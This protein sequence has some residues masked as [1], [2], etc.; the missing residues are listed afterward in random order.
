MTLGARDSEQ[1]S[2]EK[3]EIIKAINKLGGSVTAADVATETGLSPDKVTENLNLIASETGGSLQVSKDGN[4]AYAFQPG[5]AATYLAQGLKLFGLTV[6]N[7]ACKIGDFLLRISFGLGLLL[8]LGLI[9]LIL[10]PS[11]LGDLFSAEAGALFE[12]K[13]KKKTTKKTKD[14][15]PATKQAQFEQAALKSKLSLQLNSLTSFFLKCFSFLFGD[16]DPNKGLDE[17][18]WQLIARTIRAKKYALTSDELSPFTGG[19]PGDEDAVLP[20]LV[21]FNG[22]PEVTDSGNIVYVFPSLKTA[23]ADAQ[24]QRLPENLE[25]NAWHYS[26]YS[27]MDL[28]PVKI[29]ALVNLLGSWALWFMSFSGRGWHFPPPLLSFLVIYGTA[30]FVLPLTRY[31]ILQK[32]N[33]A[34]AQ[35]N[36]ERR[37]YAKRL[38]APKKEL[39]TK[40]AEASKFK[41]ETSRIEAGDIVYTTDKSLLDLPDHVDEQFND[42]GKTAKS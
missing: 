30:F 42:T 39:K 34:I 33:I 32:K 4:I 25:E 12:G 21:R 37:A 5:F 13:S 18:K 19:K 31:G 22:T 41:S 29:L 2:T 27:Q 14:K 35:R 40:L 15:A 1:M 26:K 11:F 8:S 3:S 36:E 24:Q 7:R 20:V 10:M 23:A 9:L 38:K 28:Q 17:D 6:L 16:G